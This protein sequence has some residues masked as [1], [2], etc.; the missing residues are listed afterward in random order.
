MLDNKFNIDEKVLP[1]VAFAVVFLIILIVV[2]LLGKIL[3]AS[4]SKSFLGSVDQAAGGVLGL[5]RSVFMI[6]VLLW[7]ADSLNFNFFERWAEGSLLYGNIAGFAPTV[8]SWIS[9]FF[10]FFRDVF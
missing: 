5:V 3:K 10:P 6:S 8:T 9:A 7:I 4:V 2:N 1:Y